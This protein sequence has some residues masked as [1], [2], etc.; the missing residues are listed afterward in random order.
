MIIKWDKN[1]TVEVDAVV[2]EHVV[3][4]NFSLCRAVHFISVRFSL[5]NR[6]R[7]VHLGISEVLYISLNPAL[8][9]QGV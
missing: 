8:T 2:R 3:L 7:F 6:Y 9:L 5:A 1:N 4:S